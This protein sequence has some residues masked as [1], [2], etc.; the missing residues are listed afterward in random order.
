MRGYS[1]P[2]APSYSAPRMSAPAPAPAPA[3]SG[4]G[5]RPH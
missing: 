5:A 2:S 1:A 3:P 4:G